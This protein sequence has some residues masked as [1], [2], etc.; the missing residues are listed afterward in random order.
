[1]FYSASG[2]AE[3]SGRPGT[4]KTTKLNKSKLNI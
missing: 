2:S 1:L 3:A 4:P